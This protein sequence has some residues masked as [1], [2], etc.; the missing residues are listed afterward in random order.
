MTIDGPPLGDPPPLTSQEA[1]ERLALAARPPIISRR[2]LRLHA[3]ASVA[4]GVVMGIFG[5]LFQEVRGEEPWAS[6][7]G[8]L[9]ILGAGVL[10]ALLRRLPSAPRN[11]QVLD[12]VGFV[13]TLL[14][15][16]PGVLVLASSE[17]DDAPL[18]LQCVVVAVAAMPLTFVGWRILR[19]GSR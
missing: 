9:V 1:Q 14:V 18:W 16:V 8:V 11:R 12:F 17:P 13:V 19:S 10:G 3:A 2:D 15:L 5:V 4:M 7:L 6:V